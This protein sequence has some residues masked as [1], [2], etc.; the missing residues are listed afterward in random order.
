MHSMRVEQGR[1]HLVYVH[2][3]MLLTSTCGVGRDEYGSSH[4][5]TGISND[6]LTRPSMV[7][8]HSE[9]TVV[10]LCKR[11]RSRSSNWERQKSRAECCKQDARRTVSTG[12][13]DVDC[14]DVD[15]APK[16]SLLAPTSR[17]T[18]QTPSHRNFV[19]SLVESAR[20]V[21]RPTS[22]YRPCSRL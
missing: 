6:S 9:F 5:C 7:M 22:D 16:V 20:A 12:L 17:Y 8:D 19:G 13:E 2:T 21:M 3:A 11:S 15:S 18:L 14:E 10:I 4:A 1:H